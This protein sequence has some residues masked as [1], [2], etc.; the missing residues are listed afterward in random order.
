MSRKGGQTVEVMPARGLAAEHLRDQLRELVA[1][2]AHGRTDRPVHHVHIDPPPDC[3]DPDAVI[4][5]FLDRYEAEFGLQNSQ[6]AGVYHVKAGR[7][8]AHVVWSLVRDDGSVVS[9]AHDHARREKVSRIV[10]FEC[11][12][13]FTKGKHNR[14]AAAALLKEGRADVS[15]AMLAAGLLDGRR[16]VA[17]STPRQRAQAER[18]AVPL[19]EIRTQA[20]AAWQASDDARSF[21]VALHSFDFSVA[22]GESGYVLIDRSGSV[23]SLNRVLAAAARAEGVEKITSAAVRSRLRGIN[24]QNVE[25]AKNA[26][27]ERRNT[28]SGDRRAGGIGAPVTA[29][30]PPRRAD[31]RDEPVGRAQGLVAGDRRDFGSSHERVAAARKRIRDHAAAQ[32]IGDIDLQDLIRNKGEVMAKI[33]AQNF[34]AKILAEVAP[35]GFNAHAFSDDLRMIQKP[36]P[37]RPAARIMMIDG[38]W[39]EYD[40]AGRSI[41]TWGPTG[42]AQILAAA[43]AD[44]LGVEP[45]HLAKTAS[46]GADVDALKVTKVSEDTVNSLVLWWTARGYSATDGPDGCWVT[47]GYARIRDTGDQLEIH[48]GLTV[49]VIDATILKAKEAWGGGVYLDGDWT[50][51]EQ[52]KLWIAAQRAGVKVENC[53]PSLSIQDAWQRE[54][55]ASAKSIKTICAARSAIAEATDVRDA[56]AGDLEA[57]HR[58]PQPLQAFVV[59]H[60]DD[61]QRRHLSGQSVADITA[62]LPRFRDLGQSELEEYERTGRTFTPPKPRRDDR[63]RNAAHTYSQ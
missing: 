15:D 30:E 33:R 61:D 54:Q 16:P 38:G 9:L 11:G 23:H 21:A 12:L 32:R 2:S 51:D 7:K 47:A 41:R 25:E 52:D 27:S 60:L 13:P 4:A 45:E 39:L 46:V 5:T 55:A 57:M 10:E 18:T 22:T 49:K 3:S 8:H 20:L 42:R 37:A 44:K 58:L 59:S 50:Q 53:Q 26:R 48:G 1:S 31:R 62:A 19:D 34:K 43:L 14:S 29:P 28:N 56:A 36:T 24:F 6:R 17:H 63:D 35:A 40:A